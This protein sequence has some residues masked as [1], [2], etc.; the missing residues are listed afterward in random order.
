MSPLMKAKQLA[1]NKN[2]PYMV[3]EV[4]FEDGRET[5]VY[6]YSWA[7]TEEFTAFDGKIISIHW[8]DGS[9]E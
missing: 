9:T 6:P 3:C 7:L 2:V 8:P 5:V 4:D 1:K